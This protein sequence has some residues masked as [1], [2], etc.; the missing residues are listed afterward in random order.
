MCMNLI[1]SDVV[2]GKAKED[3]IIKRFI[4]CMLHPILLQ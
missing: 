1:K 2:S 3:C 4:T